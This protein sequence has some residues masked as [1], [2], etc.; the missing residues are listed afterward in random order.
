M[1]GQMTLPT[2][3]R[4][5]YESRIAP[6]P[7]ER[8]EYAGNAEARSIRAHVWWNL[9]RAVRQGLGMAPMLASRA[10]TVGAAH[11]NPRSE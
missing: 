11:G 7:V 4:L 9:A 10:E 1:T 5:L 8:A 6:K 3:V 2:N